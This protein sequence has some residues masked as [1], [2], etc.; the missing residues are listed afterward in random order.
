[1]IYNLTCE[2][3]VLYSTMNIG[4]EMKRKKRRGYINTGERKDYRNL[5]ILNSIREKKKERKK[6]STNIRSKSHRIVSHD[7]FPF[8]DNFTC[9]DAHDSVANYRCKFSRRR[10]ATLLSS[11]TAFGC[12]FD[13]NR[14]GTRSSAFDISRNFLRD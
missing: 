7:F 6:D 8:L 14:T 11:I 9:H 4:Y 1:M 5:E 12:T 2:T 3:C 13:C 10:D